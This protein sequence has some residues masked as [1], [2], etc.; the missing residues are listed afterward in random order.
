MTEVTKIYS[1]EY[2]F[3]ALM[4]DGT[5]A[6]WDELWCNMYDPCGTDLTGVI[7]IYSTDTAFAAIVEID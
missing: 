5:V 4:A 7:D 2:A 6:S 3:A 1:T